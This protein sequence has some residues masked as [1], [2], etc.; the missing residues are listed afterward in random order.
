[1]KTASK[2]RG[3]NRRKTKSNE[4]HF[5]LSCVVLKRNNHVYAV[6]LFNGKQK[7]HVAFSFWKQT[8]KHTKTQH[9]DTNEQKTKLESKKITTKGNERWTEMQKALV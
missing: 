3:K 4:Q 2:R 6:H 5:S 9:T 7:L 8:N 1:M